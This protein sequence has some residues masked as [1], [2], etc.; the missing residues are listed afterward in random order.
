MIDCLMDVLEYLGYTWDIPEYTK[1]FKC[2]IKNKVSSNYVPIHI[3]IH[4]IYCS[5]VLVASC[6]RRRRPTGFGLDIARQHM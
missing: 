2:G 5:W 6:R 3:L 4:S 1:S